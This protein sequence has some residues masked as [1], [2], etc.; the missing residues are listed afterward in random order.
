MLVD[1]PVYRTGM[2]QLE[3]GSGSGTEKLQGTA[4]RALTWWPPKARAWGHLRVWADGFLPLHQHK[5]KQIALCSNAIAT[6][7]FE[8]Q[9]LALKIYFDVVN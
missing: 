7:I 1:P 3:R 8:K 4:L 2:L 5:F 6:L 9:N